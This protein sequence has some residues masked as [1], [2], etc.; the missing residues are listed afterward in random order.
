MRKVISFT[1]TIIIFL[2]FDISHAI[3]P[4]AYDLRDVNGRNYVTSV[5][6]QIMGTCW[7]HGTMAAIEG[8]LVITNKWQDAG[9]D[10]WPSLAEYHLDWWNGFNQHNND[11]TDP[12]TGG[13]LTVHQGGDYMV[14]AAY[15]SRGEGVV[16][17][18]DGQ[19]FYDP[20]LRTS[21]NFHYYYTRHIEFYVAGTHL[22]NINTIKEKIMSDGVMATA[23]CSSGSFL[24]NNIH[25]QPPEDSW[26][27]NHSVAIV[28]WDDY[29]PTQAPYP[30]AWLCKNS[31]G[32]NWGNDG[33]FWI[34]YYD[35]HC[36]QHPQMGAVS[37]QDVEPLPYDKIFFHDY[38]GWRDT[39]TD[40]GEAFNAFVADDDITIEAV[41]F[42][43]AV[44]NVTYTVIIYDD[45]AGGSLSGELSS[46]SG[47]VEH[48]GFHT[49]DLT[50]PVDLADGE[51]FYVYV[52]L[53]SGGHAYDM[54]SDV[55]VL[56]GADYRV[57]VESSANPGESFYHN[58]SGWVDFYDDVPTGNFCIK[59]LGNTRPSLSIHLVEDAPE[60]QLPKDSL[61]IIVQI[62]EVAH[63]YVPGTGMVY[64]RLSDGEF[65]NSQLESV[66]GGQYLASLPMANCG[67]T[68]EYYFSA[69]A[70]N[71]ET[72]YYPVEAPNEYFTTLVGEFSYKF[73]DNFDTDLGWTVDGTATDGNWERGIPVGD[74]DGGAPVTDF[75]GSGSCYLTGNSAGDSDV[76]DG[77]T[78]LLSPAF[79]LTD[80]NAVISYRRWYSN[81]KGPAP[82]GDAMYI[83]FTN[84]SSW[85]MK[86]VAGTGTQC[87]GGW[88]EYSFNPAK[89][90]SL[91]DQ[92]RLKFEV[93]DNGN[94]SSIE[95]AIDNV[96]AKCLVC[97]PYKCGDVANDD[98]INILDAV[99]LINS[100]Y[101]GG[102]PP[103]PA[104]HGDVNGDGTINILDIVYLI[105]YVYKDGPEPACP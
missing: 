74:G 40:C 96:V 42:Y 101:K 89:Y 13:G 26:D 3:P 45:F 73:F 70:D 58:G 27:P 41:S 54:T 103:E 8:N 76:D 56:L 14:V 2:I 62:D 85:R 44:D 68:Y 97:F 7:T 30:G 46:I 37:F 86:D 50:V 49:F 15:I 21:P 24:Q 102:P 104:E 17:E 1:A 94:P 12:P 100:I 88:I 55:P 43:T 38:H 23:L 65:Q 25:Y 39:K 51:D 83:Y 10:N 77:V 61:D 36:G 60:C 78:Q 57:I 22:E 80:G 4:S 19:S 91:T 53:S 79:D 63:S 48:L 75:E 69:Q 99:Y 6:D 5:K 35:K 105:N 29:L 18:V 31:W 81:N 52:E 82:Y 64:Y 47:I 92:M 20:P 59:G 98:E 95:A 32:E 90:M 84:G 16:R 71:G 11:D 28:G 87:N 67:Q 33:Y 93:A 9:E 34:S 72:V 66:G